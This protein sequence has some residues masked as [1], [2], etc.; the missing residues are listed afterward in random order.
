MHQ[1]EFTDV[2]LPCI[3]CAERGVTCSKDDKVYPPLRQAKQARLHEE[4]IKPQTEEVNAG[5]LFQITPTT[6]ESLLEAAAGESD[7]PSGTLASFPDLH[8]PTFLGPRWHSNLTIPGDT[9]TAER[10]R[11]CHEL[12]CPFQRWRERNG[13]HRY[14][15]LLSSTAVRV[16][17]PPVVCPPPPNVGA[18][19]LLK[20]SLASVVETTQSYLQSAWSSINDAQASLLKIG[21]VVEMAEHIISAAVPFAGELKIAYFYHL[22]EY[23]EA[24]HHL[25]VKGAWDAVGKA[26]ALFT[27]KMQGMS[28]AAA[29]LG[30]KCA[31]HLSSVHL[32]VG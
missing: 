16:P 17:P 4:Q 30:S 24:L 23:I 5:I 2:D 27:E 8:I 29:A 18:F 28:S 9:P 31:P 26:W 25:N 12:S 13:L 7:P 15:H 6:S 19:G 20:S 32:S 21:P 11:I 1:C 10:C 3:R 22:S 14:F